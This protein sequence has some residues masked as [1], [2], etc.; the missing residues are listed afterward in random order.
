[1]IELVEIEPFSFKEAI[2]QPVWVDAFVE[3]YESIV[4]NSVWDMVPVITQT[5]RGPKRGFLKGYY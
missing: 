1:M 5:S 4:K 3:E 2:E